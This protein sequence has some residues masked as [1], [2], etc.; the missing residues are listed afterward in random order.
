MHI[1]LTCFS[2]FNQYEKYYR[3]ILQFLFI[4]ELRRHAT[5]SKSLIKISL[6]PK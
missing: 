2:L 1:K 4:L 6:K 5:V 3:L